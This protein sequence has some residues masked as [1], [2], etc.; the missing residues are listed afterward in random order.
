MAVSKLKVMFP[1]WARYGNT[2]IDDFSEVAMYGYTEIWRYGASEILRY[3]DDE[4][5]KYF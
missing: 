1:G 2:S 4:I 5:R 3:T